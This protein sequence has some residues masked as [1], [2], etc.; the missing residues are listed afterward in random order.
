MGEEAL[1]T[2]A[3]ACAG[4][5]AHVQQR[6]KR[7]RTTK[8]KKCGNYFPIKRDVGKFHTTIE[9]TYT[10]STGWLIVLTNKNFNLRKKKKVCTLRMCQFFLCI[11]RI[12]FDPSHK[13]KNTLCDTFTNYWYFQAR[14]QNIRKIIEQTRQH[15]GYQK[16]KFRKKPKISQNEVRYNT[17]N[18]F[19]GLQYISI[20]IQL[21]QFGQSISN[22]PNQG[23][24]NILKFWKLAKTWHGI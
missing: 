12:L 5:R 8:R 9:V 10:A 14:E 20:S 16:A 22:R 4:S 13:H 21:I 17:C 1:T 11:I 3:G 18:S 6:H 23:D 24:N 2:V 15:L 7:K 19:G